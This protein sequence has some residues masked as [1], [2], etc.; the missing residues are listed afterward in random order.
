MKRIVCFL[1]M[2]LFWVWNPLTA[3][4]AVVNPSPLEYTDPTSGVNYPLVEL[5]VAGL[6]DQKSLENLEGNFYW[7]KPDAAQAVAEFLKENGR[8]GKTEVVVPYGI[9]GPGDVGYGSLVIPNAFVSGK[10]V[11]ADKVVDTKK[12]RPTVFPVPRPSFPG[13]KY[14]VRGVTEGNFVFAFP[15]RK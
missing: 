8:F 14:I 13:E 6:T 1:G 11:S 12:T 4:A 5:R 9:T 10:V 7:N 15:A 3:S 2:L